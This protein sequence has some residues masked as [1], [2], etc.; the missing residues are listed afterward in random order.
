[1]YHG[2]SHVA[3]WLVWG[4]AYEWAVG[5]GDQS[6]VSVGCAVVVQGSPYRGRCTAVPVVRG[7]TKTNFLYNGFVRPSI[8]F[9]FTSKD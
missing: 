3:A 9:L 1:M 8:H 6:P 2:L 5:S 7:G 4:T